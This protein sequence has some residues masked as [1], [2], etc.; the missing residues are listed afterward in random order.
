MEPMAGNYAA[1]IP[2]EYIINE[3]DLQIYITIQGS[4]GDCIMLP[5]VYH[6]GYPYP[7]HVIA[8]KP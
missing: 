2:G 7:Y 4:G 6:P 8:V 1:V 3:W 5:G